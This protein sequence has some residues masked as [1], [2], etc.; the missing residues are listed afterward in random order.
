MIGSCTSASCELICSALC[1]P[2]CTSLSWLTSHPATTNAV[3]HVRTRTLVPNHE[4]LIR[5]RKVTRHILIPAEEV[6][7]PRLA[8]LARDDTRPFRSPPVAQPLS[9]ASRLRR[10]RHQRVG[11]ALAL[12]FVLAVQQC[13][14][15]V[16]LDHRCA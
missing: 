15:V 9:T 13:E 6:Q 16:V 14:Q 4:R 11:H 10:P 8:S 7:I 3:A 2:Y 12:L 1:R 5:P